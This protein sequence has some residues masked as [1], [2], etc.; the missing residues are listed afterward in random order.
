LVPGRPS[1]LVASIAVVS[2]VGAFTAVRAWFA[3][4]RAA[5]IVPA[6]LTVDSQPAGADVLIDGQQRGKT[7]ATFSIDP[8]AHTLAVRAAGTQRTAQLTLAAGA[9]AAQHFDLTPT[10]AAIAPGRLS[11]V[12]DPP[13][14][15]V[16]VD[17]RARGVSPLVI[18]DLAAAEHTI[19]VTSDAGVARRTIAVTNGVTTE[20]VFSLSQPTAPVAGWV[21]VTSPFPVDL[22]EHDEVVGTS[23]TTRIM[24]A[25]G[26]HDVVLRNEAVGYE[27]PRSIEVVPG[28]VTLLEVAPPNG[29]LN[30][31][32][33][34]WADLL[35][36]GAAAGQTPLANI[37]LPA[38][39]HQLTFRHPQLGER[40]ERVVIKANGTTRVAVDLNK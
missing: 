27:A 25:A 24:L 8:G 13:G 39:P 35:I 22:V 15:R 2:A 4:V 21:A 17:G 26:R 36:D 23:G 33:R 20:V 29:L 32:A 6:R 38:G 14:L 10:A 31:N 9:Q 18:D 5:S 16:A 7:P 1:L 37:A 11:I 12:T 40:I 30:V 19:T 34:P 3:P 28:R